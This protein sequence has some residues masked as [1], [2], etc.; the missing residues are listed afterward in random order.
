MAL[1]CYS[2]DT[3]PAHNNF[4][5]SF[6]MH[7]V[8]ATFL[9]LLIIP[10]QV[11]LVNIYGRFYFHQRIHALFRNFHCIFYTI[12]GLYQL[13]KEYC[14]MQEPMPE[15]QQDFIQTLPPLDKILCISTTRSIHIS[16]P[17]ELLPIT[18]PDQQTILVPQQD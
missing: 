15:A 8:S 17:E 4:D 10:I 18:T 1:D 13:A 7:F 14:T 5:G 16:Q 2:N 11:Q 9:L 3:G 12:L 6:V